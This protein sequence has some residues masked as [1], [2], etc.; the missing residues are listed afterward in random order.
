VDAGLTNSFTNCGNLIISENDDLLG[1]DSPL[2]ENFQTLD[3]RSAAPT[4]AQIGSKP[5]KVFLW[6]SN[7]APPTL[8][9]SY[10]DAKTNLQTK[11]SQ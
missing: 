6:V 7:G 2:N 9:F 11:W 4:F 3:G 10:Y 1:H 8:Y 5:G